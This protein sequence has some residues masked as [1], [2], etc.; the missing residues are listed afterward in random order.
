MTNH[1]TQ[2]LQLN[3]IF[4]ANKLH[5]M[6]LQGVYIG[7]LDLELGDVYEITNESME[8]GKRYLC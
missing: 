4:S 8:I 6:I 2:A 1:L 3:N 7:P 5:K